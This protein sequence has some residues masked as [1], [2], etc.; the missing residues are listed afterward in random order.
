MHIS[1]SVDINLEALWVEVLS[2]DENALR[3]IHR[4]I[5]SPL[6]Q[7]AETLL[8]DQQLADDAVQ[9]VFIKAWI[10]RTKTGPLGNV[11]AYFFA[12][13]RRHCLN[14]LRNNKVT[15]KRRSLWKAEQPLISFSAEDIIVEHEEADAL[16]IQIQDLLNQLPPRQ[17]EVIYLKYFNNM[18]YKQIALI[19]GIG[20]QSVVN[21]SFKAIHFLKSAIKLPGIFLWV[22]HLLA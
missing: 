5:F 3:L 15:I 11:K 17:R 13:I 9:E 21:H 4:T 8:N 16:K 20:Y 22:N 7:Y 12:L 2:D 19:L 1:T 6:L 14:L 10:K 18:E